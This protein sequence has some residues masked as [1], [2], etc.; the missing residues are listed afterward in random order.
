MPQDYSAGPYFPHNGHA[1]PL[2]R[3][4]LDQD[5]QGHALEF[6]VEK[7][8]SLRMIAA[9]MPVTGFDS[10]QGLPEDWRPGYPQGALACGP[11]VVRNSR[12]VAGWFADTLPMFDFS[13]VEPIG[14][15]H[16]DCDLYSSTA[17]VLKHVVPHLKSGCYLCFDEFHGY[18]GADQHEQRAWIEYTDNTDLGWNVVGHSEQAWAIRLA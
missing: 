13:G 6:G 10:F 1:Y 15:V 7:G 11:P 4:I 2:L 16:I 14:L 18:A 5:P 8:L 12:L 3:H 9:V 17:T